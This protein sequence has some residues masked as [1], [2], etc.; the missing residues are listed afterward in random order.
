MLC[1]QFGRQRNAASLTARCRL[2]IRNE[3]F[4]VAKEAG[5][6]KV[7]GVAMWLR[8]RPVGG[9]QSWTQWVNSWRFWFDQLA[10]NIWHGRGGLNVKVS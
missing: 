4:Y 8:P 3:L 7:L 10:V 5:S 6:D 2:G 9:K 1:I